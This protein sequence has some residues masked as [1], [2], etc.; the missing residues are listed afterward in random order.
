MLC[1]SCG[2]NNPVAHRFCGMC[3]TP[4]PQR[5]L[6]VPA[7]QST[8]TFSSVPLEITSAASPPVEPTAPSPLPPDEP[9]EPV[10]P[11][12]QTLKQPPEVVGRE[13]NYEEAEGGVAAAPQQLPAADKARVTGE[14][15]TTF[16]EPRP[17]DVASPQPVLEI[18]KPDLIER[19]TVAEGPAMET[20]LPQPG[21]EE[22]EPVSVSTAEELVSARPAEEPRFESRHPEEPRAAAPLPTVE[23]VEEPAPIKPEPELPQQRETS[24]EPPI[25]KPE[26]PVRKQEPFLVRRPAPRSIEV[27][28]T[29]AE[30]A[31]RKT[32]VVK[33]PIMEPF[34]P[35]PASAGMPTFKEVTE[36]AGA[37][38]ISAFEPSPPARPASE[39]QE[40]KEFIANFFYAPPDESVDELTMRSE[41]PVI[42][43]ETPAE[44]HHPS[45]DGDA[46]PPP[47]AHPAVPEYVA[48]TTDRSRFLEMTDVPAAAERHQPV[49]PTPSFLGLDRAAAPSS[50]AVLE[51]DAPASRSR[52]L[53]WSLLAV[54]LV[55]F[56]ALGFL[57]GRAQSTQTLQGPLE[58]VR[59]EYAKLGPWV[60]GV[61]EAAMSGYAQLRQRISQ[62]SASLSSA[63]AEKPAAE[64]Q[65][66]AESNP[67]PSDQATASG[68]PQPDNP[69]KA[70]SATTANANATNEPEPQPS[71]TSRPTPPTETGTPA[72]LPTEAANAEPPK[73]IA[74]PPPASSSKPQPG[75]QEFAKAMEANDP[76][77]AAAWLWRSTSRG[78]PVAPVRLA[79]MYIRGQGVPRSCEQALVLL[80]SAATRENAP[81][82]NRLA[83]LYANGTCVSRDRV[84]AYELMSSALAADPNSEWAKENRQQIWNQMT[85]PERAEVQKFH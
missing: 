67:Q 84:K 62:T 63:R 20:A 82:R 38:D 68:N 53:L 79:D 14:S 54:L 50:T 76:A 56:G 10:Q 26:P 32:A 11:K 58:M 39:D 16:F 6:T 83:A 52:W 31:P 25:R 30:A 17:D 69:A 75:Q 80:R 4:F 9:L 73:P 29:S 46:L 37:P 72:T 57:E 12:V 74:A 7:A 44:F 49:A 24:P 78:N 59:S 41:V 66:P 36:A 23:A 51:E 40:L 43:K 81:A 1:S 77:A 35:P 85:P 2:F 21:L 28:P 5:P 22:P 60:S 55:V 45:F 15:D 42:D 71:A 48:T 70:D 8:I 27:L 34:T 33:P 18:V 13:T 19:A 61:K 65:K 47:E 64:Q 3:G